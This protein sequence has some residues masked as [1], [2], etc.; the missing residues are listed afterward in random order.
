MAE[1]QSGREPWQLV[2]ELVSNAWDESTTLC[3][4]TV[5]SLTPKTAKVVVTDDGGGFKSV[6]DAWTIYGHTDKRANPNTRGRYNLGEKEIISIARDATI[7]T[8]GK[9]IHF[10]KEGGR[11]VTNDPKPSKGTVVTCIVAW[12]PRQ[13]EECVARLKELL[14]PRGMSYIVNGVP[15]LWNRPLQTIEGTLETIIQESVDQPMRTTKRKTGIEIFNGNLPG[16]K[17]YEM[18]I[19]I[20]DIDSDY[21]FNILQKVPMPPN[22]DTVRER[23]LR[24]L[25]AIATEAMAPVLPDEQASSQWVRM[26]VE[27]QKLAPATLDIIKKKRFGTNVVLRSTDVQANECAEHNGYTV[28]NSRQ[29]SR[30]EREA[31]A[32][33]GVVSAKE[34][35]GSKY[36]PGDL[37]IEPTS[38]EIPEEKWDAGM[39]RVAEYTRWLAKELMQV[40]LKVIMYSEI[41]DAAAAR[42]NGRTVVMFNKF[43]LGNAWFEK[44]TPDTTG[45]L[46]HEFAHCL[47][48]GHDTSYNHSLADLAGKCVHLAVEKHGF[49]WEWYQ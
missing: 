13:V 42:S 9:I 28:L 49:F 34:Q 47:G 20:Q 29:F 21:S 1:L 25:Y 3:T 5:V 30:E 18:G 7:R 2:K 24:D 33:V 32:T 37:T 31:Y 45:T 48:T 41:N 19:P 39:R 11:V 22:R 16:H 15:I 14:T 35:F 40:D 46:L 10:P 36:K 44:I 6:E 12:G 38:N 23:Y 4:A 26:A 17:I 8:S 43:R 27:S